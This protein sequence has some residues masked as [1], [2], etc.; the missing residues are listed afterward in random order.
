MVG[1]NSALDAEF[2]G[3]TSVRLHFGDLVFELL[4]SADT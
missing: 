4:F 3:V 1:D 2:V